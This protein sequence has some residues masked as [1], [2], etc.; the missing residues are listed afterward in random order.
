MSQ[1]VAGLL[2]LFLLIVWLD[3]NHLLL[4]FVYLFSTRIDNVWPSRSKAFLGMGD[5]MCNRWLQHLKTFWIICIKLFML[6]DFF[7]LWSYSDGSHGISPTVGFYR[8]TLLQ[9]WYVA[10]SVQG[11][12]L[13]CIYT[14]TYKTSFNP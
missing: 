9:M 7:S 2:T 8:L 5:K 1:D 13:P 10:S 14:T 4:L 6:M 12:F 11:K 3:I